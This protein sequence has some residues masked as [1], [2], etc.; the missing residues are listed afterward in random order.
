ME[1]QI[2]IYQGSDG[3]TQIEVKFEQDTVWLDAHSMASIY[4]VHRPAVVKH[5]NNIY[6]SGELKS[7]STC[8]ILEQVA[9]D[10]KK[11]KMNL[12]NLDMIISVGYRVN[13]SKATLFRQWATQRLKDFL[14]QGYAI[15][16][17]V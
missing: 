7:E 16:E 14:V 17:N 10:G 4:E 12:Y 13:S 5:I 2:E 15:N 11:R 1:N 8:S 9:A 6:K 3:Q